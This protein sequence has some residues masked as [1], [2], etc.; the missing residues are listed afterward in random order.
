MS[1]AGR[2]IAGPWFSFNVADSLLTYEYATVRVTLYNDGDEN[3]VIEES[4]KLASPYQVEVSGV[5]Q[6][7]TGQIF[8]V[9]TGVNLSYRLRRNG[10]AGPW[11]KR[12][13]NPGEEDWQLEF[14]TVN[15]TLFNDTDSL[16]EPH[17]V[18]V[19]GV[20][21]FTTGQVFHVPP[22]VQ[23]SYRLRRNGIAGPW[24]KRD[25]DAGYEDWRL[26]YATVNVTLFNGEVILGEPHRVEV[27]GVGQFTTDQVFHVPPDVQLSYRLR[28][29]GIAG[30][31]LKQAF[32][33]GD[34]DW[35]LEFATVHV[36]LFND[37]N[38]DDVI[39]DEE[40]L[41]DPHRVEISGVGQ[42]T[43]DQVFHVPPDVQLSY[44]LRRNG[45]AGPWL[46]RN[47]DAGY[48]DWQLE[49]ATVHVTLFNGDETL[50]DPHRVEVSGV[51]QFTTDQ[52]F[53]VPPDV[54]LSYRLRR[55]GLA[56]PWLK[57]DFDAGY[58]D[59]RLEFA[60]VVFRFDLP[61]DVAALMSTEI[62]GFGTLPHEGVAHLPPEITIKI[63]A[64]GSGW[65]T[66]WASI[67]PLKAGVGVVTWGTTPEYT[68]PAP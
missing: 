68:P 57:R 5:G 10:I 11:L 48:G 2:R 53:H 24:L 15:V 63:I 9:P 40:K 58:E 22:D 13:F 52:V 54:Q 12:M 26:E 47:F 33:A 6:F 29:N 45:I 28:R 60:T 37:T 21:Q 20:G 36:T 3:D 55:N 56:A 65:T 32:V 51:G 44:R 66:A 27:S 23:I 35:Q 16:G 62:S 30:P 25:F 38:G 18:E 50:A 4:E 14:A 31:W 67:G 7:V 46:K 34:V 61:T 17:R 19:S 42:F 41:A 43:T 49:F 8:H 64:R 1:G 39:Q 59:W